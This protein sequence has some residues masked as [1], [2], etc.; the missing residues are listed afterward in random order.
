MRKLVVPNDQYNSHPHYVYDCSLPM[1]ER[2]QKR[3]YFPTGM[4]AANW[5]G[6]V[7][8]RVYINRKNKARIWSEAHSGWFAVRIANE[9]NKQVCTTDM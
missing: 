4:A 5:L 7:P 8:Q 1:P 3:M 6:V 2:H 9:Q